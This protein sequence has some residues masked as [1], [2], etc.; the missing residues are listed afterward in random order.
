[1]TRQLKNK[2]L[3]E[4]VAIFLLCW[5]PGTFLPS[6]WLGKITSV[7]LLLFGILT[8]GQRARPFWEVVWKQRRD[9]QESNSHYGVV[10]DFLIAAGVIYA[11]VYGSWYFFAGQPDGWAGTMVSSFWRILV[12]CGLWYNYRMAQSTGPRGSAIAGKAW[13]AVSVVISF[14]LG[15]AVMGQFRMG[16]EGFPFPMRLMEPQ[17]PKERPYWGSSRKVYHGPDSPYRHMVSPGACFTTEQEA[18]DSGYRK[19]KK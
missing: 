14:L 18:I 11:G 16:S 6:E 12:G 7:F 17:C 8:L 10:G 1:V 9:E 4:L 2:L 13:I 5:G 19:W 15:M 3:I